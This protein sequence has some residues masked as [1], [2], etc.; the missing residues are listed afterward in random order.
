MKYY[1]IHVEGNEERKKQLQKLSD[2]LGS[3]ITLQLT[4]KSHKISDRLSDCTLNHVKVLT[5]FLQSEEREATIFE[6]DAEIVDFDGMREFYL[7]APKDYDMLYFGLKEY[8]NYKGHGVYAETTRSWGAHAYLVNRWAATCIVNEYNCIKANN[9][10]EKIYTLPP[11]WLINYAIQ[12]WELK[13]YGPETIEKS[14]VVQKGPSLIV[15]PI[16]VCNPGDFFPVD[17]IN[18]SEHPGKVPASVDSQQ[19][20]EGLEGS[21]S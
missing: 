17:Y 11:D 8:V 16:I 7:N 18:G 20:A 21:A 6:D 13:A 1:A 4:Q 14:F 10:P 5:H 2:V 12:D 3:P 15:P 9:P 19:T